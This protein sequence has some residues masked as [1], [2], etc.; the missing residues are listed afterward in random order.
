MRV[1]GGGWRVEGL[2]LRVEGSGFRVWGLGFR[3][4]GEPGA[5]AHVV[6]M[7]PHPSFFFFFCI[8]HKPKV[9]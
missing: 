9:E 4:Q 6:D 3:V 8:T 7:H 5:R 2:E 1:E